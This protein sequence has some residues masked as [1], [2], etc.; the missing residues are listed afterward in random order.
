MEI[1]PPPPPLAMPDGFTLEALRSLGYR[2]E[3]VSPWALVAEFLQ[4]ATQTHLEHQRE[5]E[6]W[7]RQLEEQNLLVEQAQ[8]DNLNLL[9][10][11]A[12]KLAKQADQSRLQ[13]ELEESRSECKRLASIVAFSQPVVGLT[14]TAVPT[15]ELLECKE[16]LRL[17]SELLVEASRS[18]QQL[19]TKLQQVEQRCHD[20]QAAALDKQSDRSSTTAQ[21]QS[22]LAVVQRN[23][24]KA[25]EQNQQLVEQHKQ[26][27]LAKEQTESALESERV[28]HNA[29][30]SELRLAA[31]DVENMARENRDLTA[32]SES[33]ERQLRDTRAQVD[34][35][36]TK[37]AR[38]AGLL[39]AAKVER[40]ELVQVYQRACKEVEDHKLL[41]RDLAQQ[42]AQG[43]QRE[44]VMRQSE[45]ETEKQLALQAS[46]LRQQRVDLD[47]LERMR[48]QMTREIRLIKLQLQETAD[49]RTI[50]EKL[51]GSESSKLF[52]ALRNSDQVKRELD[53]TQVELQSAKSRLEQLREENNQL[54]EGVVTERLRNKE[55]SD[56]V[57]NQRATQ[58]KALRLQPPTQ[59]SLSSLSSSTS[60]SRV[61]GEFERVLGMDSLNE[62]DLISEASSVIR[63]TR[64]G[65]KA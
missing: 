60:D 9:A 30:L 12:G 26:L 62:E 56:T 23:L 14:T 50:A 51:Q 33:L 28:L 17:S 22:Q 47:N 32:H 20:L 16:E 42:V 64:L 5:K 65:R 43:A 15:T 36:H 19:E 27:V 4:R 40:D 37:L 8:Q 54:A 35:Q 58:A 24:A 49:S 29:R 31:L 41:V 21:V 61:F 39:D 6:N 63:Q 25:L 45:L 48:D 7:L 38:L 10:E 18:K 53:A 46:Q 13:E 59:A 11:I 55:L 44:R 3:D 57:S 52:T 1:P 2:V 34:E